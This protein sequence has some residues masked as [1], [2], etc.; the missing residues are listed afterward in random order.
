VASCAMPVTPNM[1]V[2]TKSAVT[3]N[4]REGV[5][6][7]LLANHPLDC[8]ICDQGGEC[9]LQDQSMVYGNDRSRYTEIDHRGKRATEDKNLGPLIKTSMNRCIHCTRCIRFASEVA[10]VDELGTTGRGNSTQVG[11]YVDKMFLSEMSGNIVDLCPVGALT[12]KPYA[13]TARPWELRKTESIDVHDA[14]GSN[15][16]VDSRGGEVMRI[17]A[18]LHEEINEE[19]LSDK[20][21]YSYDGLKRQRLVAPMMKDRISG[22]LKKIDWEDALIA[23]SQALNNSV[24]EGSGFTI[25]AGGLADVEAMVAVKDL[26]NK[27][28][29]EN[30]FMEGNFNQTSTSVSSDLRSNYIMNGGLSGIDESD[31]VLIVGSNTRYEAPLLNSRIRRCFVQNELRVGVI[32]DV[33][34]LNFD[35]DNIGS[36]AGILANIASGN[37]EWSKV[38]KEAKNPMIIV[39]DAALRDSTQSEAILALTKKIASTCKNGLDAYNVLHTNAGTVGALD[40]G[41]KSRNDGKLFAEACKNAKVLYLLEADDHIPTRQEIGE[42]VFVIYQGSHGDKGAHLADIILP[43]S[44]YTEKYGTYTN[45]EG[46]AQHTQRVVTAPGVSREGWQI[47]RAI[48]EFCGKQLKYDNSMDMRQRLDEIAPHLNRHDFREPSAF[49]NLAVQALDGASITKPNGTKLVPKIQ[50]LKDFYVT[51]A[52]TRSSQIMARCIKAVEK[53]EGIEGDNTVAA[54]L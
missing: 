12:S 6:E 2:N 30:V 48:S 23:V 36:D 32:G 28:D 26:A 20:T 50:R 25:L 41:Y 35:Y 15:I 7:F 17:Q 22:K 37:H 10:G 19:W 54:N 8:P 21:R 24:K 3:K 5:M 43:S 46:R 33:D 40:I 16:R 13:F 42:D 53:K 44:A 18:R 34:N 45:T 38:L 47:V 49:K 31:V 29:S 51:N 11:T 9:D 39:G 1:V 27:Y 14:L 4:A 52:I